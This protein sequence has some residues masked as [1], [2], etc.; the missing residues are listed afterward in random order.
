MQPAV[1]TY[2]ASTVA[3]YIWILFLA[4]FLL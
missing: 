4:L 1:P 2:S 3:S